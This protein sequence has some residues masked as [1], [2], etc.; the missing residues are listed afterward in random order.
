MGSSTV[1]NSQELS[2]INSFRNQ[3]FS[4]LVSRTFHVFDDL[5]HERLGE[6]RVVQ[7]I[8]TH[9]TVADNVNDYVLSESLA[10]L[11]SVLKDLSDIFHGVSVNMENR[12]VNA[13]SDISAVST[14]SSLVR[15]GGKSNL[16]VDYDVN[17]TSNVIVFKG[18]HLEGLLNNSL[19]SEG[20]VTMDL[21]WNH[22]SSVGLISTEEMLLSASSATDNGVDSFQMGRVSENSNFNLFVVVSVGSSQSCSEMVLDITLTSESRLSLLVRTSSL[23]F[24]HDLL[25][26]LPHYVS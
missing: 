5:V 1:L 9:L 3:F 6:T 19:T 18:L 8:M 21:D 20:C 10:V 12:G 16:V 25:H 17:G 23:E 13:L 14:R 15:S 7:F 4:E 26:R 22:T 24:S 11:S 2:L